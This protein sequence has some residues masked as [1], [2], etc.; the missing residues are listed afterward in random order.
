MVTP[1][2]YLVAGL[3]ISTVSRVVTKVLWLYMKPWLKRRTDLK[4]ELD[5]LIVIR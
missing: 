2:L 1:I 4:K 3:L 5:K